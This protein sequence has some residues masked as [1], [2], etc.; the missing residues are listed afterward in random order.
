[1][2]L[3]ILLLIVSFALLVIAHE[4]GHFIVAKRNGIHVYEFG[5]GFPPKLKGWNYKGTEYT[6][7]LLPL[8]GFVRLE[9]EN[10][11]SNTKASFAT[12]SFWIKTKVL[13]AGVAVNLLIAYLLFV[14]LC[15][16]GFANTFPFELPTLGPVQPITAGQSRLSA[17]AVSENSAASQAGLTTGDEIVSINN[18]VP[19]S[20]P[21]LRELTSS[22][23]GQT[24]PFAYKHEGKV[25]ERTVTLGSDSDKGVLG[26]SAMSQTRQRYALWAAPIAGAMLIGKTVAV[27]IPMLFGGIA[28]LITK[29]QVPETLVGPVGVAAVAPTIIRFGWDY[30]IMLV[31][32]ISL[33]LAIF[34]AL[35]IPALDGGRWFFLALRK[36]GVPIQDHH[37]NW[38]HTVAF[39][40]LL[41]LGVVI[42]VANLSLF[43]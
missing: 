27:S 38:V 1:M 30:F 16:V 39:V 22:L 7:N 26:V 15:I 2:I 41:G 8:G 3:A 13:F 40:L 31:A 20:E 24:V 12:K 4:F 36:I 21:K 19:E 42:N 23:A 37:E 6:I 14:G 9:G 43:R 34:N 11:E 32:S 17:M 10:N 33:S 18:V 5:I 29:R 35:P 25:V 28:E